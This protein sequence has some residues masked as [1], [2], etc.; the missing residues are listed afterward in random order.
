MSKK[1]L[2]PVGVALLLIAGL[3]VYGVSTGMLSK[4]SYSDEEMDMND[5]FQIFRP[6][7]LALIL[8]DEVIEEQGLVQEETYYL[9]LGLVQDKFNSRFYYDKAESQIL[10]TTPTQFYQIPLDAS[11]YQV[12]GETK[13]FDHIIAIRSEETVYLSIDYLKQFANF[14]YE[15]F[16][17]PN[18]L[19]L[20]LKDS[21]ADAATI[22][23]D[24]NLRYQGGVKSDI[25]EE[26]YQD[27]VVTVLETMEKWSKV[28]SSDSVIGYVENKYLTDETTVDRKVEKTYEEPEYTSIHKEEKINLA[29]HQV[30]TQEANSGVSR[31]L[32]TTK[33]IN[34]ISPTWF[35][36]QS[37]EG[38][39]AS[40]A[41]ADY[42]AD[43]HSR[44]I[45]VWGLVDNFTSKDYSMAKVLGSTSAR[46]NLIGQLIEKALEYDL[47][48]I[49]VD[50][51]SI[52]AECGED[53]IQL[54][55]ELSIE[56][57]KNELVLSVDN[58]VPTSFTAH[59][60]RKEQGMIVDYVII[61]GYDEHYA[62]SPEAGSVASIDYVQQGII[63]TVEAVPEEK[64][65]NGIPFYTRI[66]DVTGDV[67]SEAVGMAKAKEFLQQNGVEATWDDETCQNVA[68]F[69]AD[70]RKYA[71]WMEDDQSIRAKLSVMKQYR[72][73][74]VAE[75]K[76][77]F[78][79]P[80]IWDLI[81]DYLKDTDT[82]GTGQTEAESVSS[83]GMQQTVSANGL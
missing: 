29:W 11:A 41:S 37:D 19:Q 31:L 17:E 52:D 48:G 25:L 9:P 82:F 79:T 63:D 64:V 59:Y 18:R 14:S 77:G 72:L 76:L 38:D 46:R 15:A 10:Y 12:D 66:W 70:G 39:I 50:F 6:D 42:V 69:T 81:V 58:Y 67:T 43:M 54:L 7:A 49:N 35:Y 33:G 55:R 16:D 34:V 71:V 22:R 20:Y 23:K 65:I 27:E 28:K 83:N 73:A 75:W 8:E 36:L 62:G 56:C 74:G 24:T 44:G 53:Y 60:N 26:L 3:I 51:E 45:D 61:M 57:R 4:Y 80:D 32:E 21:T 5:Y 13:E 30:T 78:E 2:I 1:Q 40:V 68:K 47:D